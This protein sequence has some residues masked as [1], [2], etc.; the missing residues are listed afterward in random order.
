[1]GWHLYFTLLSKGSFYSGELRDTRAWLLG[2]TIF[3]LLR[4]VATCNNLGHGKFIIV[5]TN[6][7]W[8]FGTAATPCFSATRKYCAHRPPERIASSQHRC[9]KIPS[10]KT[11]TL[12]GL[13][14]DGWRRLWENNCLY[15]SLSPAKLNT[16][17]SGTITN[18]GAGKGIILLYGRKLHQLLSN[19]NKV[20]MRLKDLS[21]VYSETLAW[22]V[23]KTG[24]SI[25]L[26][27]FI[28]LV[29]DPKSGEFGA[30]FF[31]FHFLFY[32]NF[33]LW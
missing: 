25:I 2:H 33:Q 11:G 4:R 3:E 30:A 23:S 32:D 9:L 24:N 29:K 15:Q 17:L 1:M 21:A 13:C 18:T 20:L 14:F 22:K 7:Y 31:F 8:R 16:A 19:I 5:S 28:L 12:I 10:R 6:K 27:D 26:Q